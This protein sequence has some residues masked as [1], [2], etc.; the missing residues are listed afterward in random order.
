MTRRRLLFF[1]LLTLG[2]DLIMMTPEDCKSYIRLSN[3][4]QRGFVNSL[5]E[6]VAATALKNLDAASH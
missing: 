3:F 5:C 2:S 1:L 4:G 6:R